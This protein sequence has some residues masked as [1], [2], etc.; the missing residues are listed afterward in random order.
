MNALIKKILLLTLPLMLTACA[1]GVPQ[2]YVPS[3]Y[4]V[5]VT[6]APRYYP[7]QH[8]Q[9]PVYYVKPP[10]NQYYEHQKGYNKEHHDNGK[11]KGHYKHHD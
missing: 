6:P 11:H 2:S 3:G 10:H 1:Y 7:N 9:P 5:H 8:K 4:N